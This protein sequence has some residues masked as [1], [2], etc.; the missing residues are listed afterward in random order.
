MVWLSKHTW[1]SRWN[2]KCSKARI[3]NHTQNFNTILKMMFRDTGSHLF[4]KFNMLLSITHDGDGKGHWQMLK[5]H[6]VRQL[7]TELTGY[8]WR[9][10]TEDV[11]RS[12]VEAQVSLWKQRV[13]DVDNCHVATWTMVASKK[14]HCQHP[15]TKGTLQSCLS[16]TPEETQCTRDLGSPV[17][18]KECFPPVWTWKAWRFISVMSK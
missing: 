7:W 8:T 12:A 13:N 16:V 2:I 9:L 10:V 1:K 5:D 15:T 6:S 3:H 11:L 17:R 4:H 18:I 14:T